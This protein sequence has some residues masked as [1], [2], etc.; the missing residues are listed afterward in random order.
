MN[1]NKVEGGI[2]YIFP[3]EIGT[4]PGIHL[5]GSVVIMEFWKIDSRHDIITH[6]LVNRAENNKVV[7]F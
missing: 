5:K 4:E 7:L 3:L 6:W 1:Q 2:V